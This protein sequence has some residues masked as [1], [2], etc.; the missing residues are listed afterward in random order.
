M[1]SGSKK[2]GLLV[3]G[4]LKEGQDVRVLYRIVQY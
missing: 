2:E 3:K 4:N 1:V